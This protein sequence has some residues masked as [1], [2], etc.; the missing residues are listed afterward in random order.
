MQQLTY[1]GPDALEWREAR[2]PRLSSDRAA[3]LRPLA[4]A[5]CDLDALIIAGSSP[6]PPPFALGHEC[7]A[8]VLDVGDAVTSLEPGRHRNEHVLGVGNAHEIRQESAPLLDGGTEAVA[9]HERDAR[10]VARATAQ[11]RCTFAAGDLEGHAD[12]ATRLERGDR[13]AG[14]ENLRDAFVTERE[15]R[16]K[17]RGALDDQRV[18]VARGDR[19]R[20]DQRGPVRAQPRLG[21]LAPLERVGTGIRELLHR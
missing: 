2:E 21:R 15:R 7:V 16:R 12:E 18:E 5:T 13:R 8:E 1:A 10:A 20:P 14:V 9:R 11:A 17:R 19:Q 4:V 3:L 6:F